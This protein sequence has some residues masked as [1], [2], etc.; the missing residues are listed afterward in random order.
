M[1]SKGLKVHETIWVNNPTSEK[2]PP[3]CH[4]AV[5]VSEGIFCHGFQPELRV[6]VKWCSTNKTE[7]VSL[8]RCEKMG[9]KKR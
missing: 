3:H 6:K 2:N 8:D 1:D 4:M 7:W 5:I 9:K